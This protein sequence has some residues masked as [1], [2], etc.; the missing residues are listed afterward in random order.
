MRKTSKFL[1]A[2]AMAV[3]FLALAN[4]SPTVMAKSK[5][6]KSKV[7]YTLKK[8]TLTI[9]G[10]GEMPKKMTFKNNKKV[11][12][13]VIKNGVTS[14]SDK[15]FY[16]CKNLS[17]VTIGKSV[18]KIGIDS[19]NG[20]KI[21]KVTIPKKV[22]EIGQDA[23]ENCKQLENIT[24]PGKYTLK[25]KKGDD[26]YATI[27]GGSMA[28]TVTFS[29]SIDLKTVTYVNSNVFDVS[30]NDK[31][32]TSK[33]GM[34]Y[35]KDGKTLVRVS[36]GTKELSIDEGCETFALQ[37]ILYAR[38]FDGDDY[39]VCDKLEK[40]RIPASVKKIDYNAYQ[41]GDYHERFDIGKDIVISGA[42]LD[43][44]SV[45]NLC[46]RTNLSTWE[47]IAKQ[48]PS[49]KVEN[50]MYISKDNVL[51]GYEGKSEKLVVPEG[52]TTIANNVIKGEGYNPDS[53]IAK[54]IVIPDTVKVIEDRAFF[55]RYNLEKVTLPKN[56]TEIG[57]YAFF[58]CNIKEI[59]IPNTITKWGKNVFSSCALE[60]V[61][62]PTNIKEI[63]EGMFEGCYK[64]KNIVIP[65]NVEKIN[66]GAF[67]NCRNLESVTI[68]KNVKSIGKYAF[69]NT[70]L[71]TITIPSNVQ[72]ID[73]NAFCGCDSLEKFVIEGKTDIANG[74]FDNTSNV[75][76]D[77]RLGAQYNKT[78]VQINNFKRD[79]KNYLKVKASWAKVKGISGYEVKVA[80]DKKFKKNVKNV[81]VNETKTTVTVKQKV[82][83]VYN[84]KRV[85]VKVTPYTYVN[86]KKVYGKSQTDLM[87]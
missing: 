73:F 51:I 46:N 84:I 72:K 24:L 20:T 85:Y 13:V 50:G 60:K 34:I 21:K 43:G 80:T 36:A 77:Y 8:G 25:K 83:N 70:K 1:F 22:K 61:T 30:A 65:D 81:K 15:A 76:L 44:E 35:T 79:K 39:V 47:N 45:V 4:P 52:I 37:S 71:T 49:I 74:V 67:W 55:S 58:E 3:T 59:E 14:V 78:S 5:G 28:D 63:P 19:F 53:K 40:I 87:K 33:S 62:I 86:G 75:V 69:Q 18:K 6:K 26:A 23:F 12:K 54:E 31:N 7:V 38:H 41:A 42:D 11:K 82:K 56:L 9:S 27:M 10:K 16:K 2:T 64:L 48:V 66:E 29:T 57:D 17:K 68:G 32:Y